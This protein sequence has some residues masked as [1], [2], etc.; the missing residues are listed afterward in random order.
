MNESD[1]S[2]LQDRIAQ[3][4]SVVSE[5][6]RQVAQ[7]NQAA[8]RL[9]VVAPSPESDVTLRETAVSPPKTRPQPKEPSPYLQSE[10]WLN[11][12]GIGLILF[13]LAFLFKFA[14]DQGWLTPTVRLAIGLLVGTGL[15]FFGLRTYEKRRHFS[16]VLL[17]GSMASYYITG[18]AAFQLYE[19]IS[20]PVAFGFMILVTLLTFALSLRQNEAVLALIGALGGF[21]TPFL[22]YTGS[23]NVPGLILYTCLLIAGTVAIYFFR[24]WRVLLWTSAALGWIIIWVG[25]DAALSGFTAVTADVWA[26]QIGIFFAWVSFWGIPVFRQYLLKN[27]TPSSLQ[28]LSLGFADVWLPAT[29]KQWLGYDL[30]L[31]TVTTALF[32]LSSR[33]LWELSDTQFGSLVI[34]FALLYGLI[35]FYLRRASAL[36]NLGITHGVAATFLLTIAF[37]I[38]LEDEALLV[39]LTAEAI[40]WHFFNHRLA[41]RWVRAGVH[42]FSL[43]IGM[44][45]FS[46]LLDIGAT[47]AK[48]AVR[49]LV[50]LAVII[51]FAA[52][53]VAWLPKIGQRVYL[54]AAHVAVLMLFWRELGEL[55]N[56][57]G[58]IS[59]AWGIYAIILLLIGLRSRFSAVRAV[60]LATL[61]VLVGKLFLVD[62]T[63]LKPIW[64]ILLFFGFGGVFLLLSYFYQGLWMTKPAADG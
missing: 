41:N 20:F 34:A 42:F 61:F 22:L 39:A 7:L 40:V 11:K 29:V 26:I 48:T 32:L 50:D 14:V 53:A 49:I 16:V 19:L 52:V 59:I 21:G 33:P 47:D 23:S 35:A 9:D 56:G 51:G 15:L 30:H 27:E 36:A 2:S 44:W 17:G 46:R 38:M 62:L 45:T 57:Q 43:I 58:L 55:N 8:E 64:R 60:G 10:F 5:L 54:L 25:E 28:P 4:E 37:L 1:D 3:L 6:Q 13:A 31:L 18:F 24:G 12:I 63:N